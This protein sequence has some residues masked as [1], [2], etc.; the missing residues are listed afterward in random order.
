MLR[1]CRARVEGRFPLQVCR[2]PYARYLLDREGGV[3]KVERKV[4]SLLLAEVPLQVMRVL[5]TSKSLVGSSFVSTEVRCLS[6]REDRW[7]GS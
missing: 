1:Q 3:R 2:T 6:Y 4:Q 7:W 5:H